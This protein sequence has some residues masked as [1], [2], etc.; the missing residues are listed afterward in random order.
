MNLVIF[1]CE[2]KGLSSLNSIMNEASERGINLFAMVCQETYLQ[3]PTQNRDKFQILTNCENTN[4]TYSKTLGVTLPFKPDWLLVSRERWD[5]ETSIILEFKQNFGCKVGLVEP[6]SWILGNAEVILEI[7]SRNRFKD[8]IDVFFTHSSYQ[9]T[10]QKKLGFVGNMVL[11]GNPKYDINLKPTDKDIQS[12]KSYYNVDPYRKKVLLFSLVNTNRK[13]LFKEF[14]KYVRDNPQY[15]FYFKPYPGEPFLP[16]FKNEYYPNFFIKGVTPILEESHIWAM[17]NICDIHI[18]C[19]SSIFH[20]SLLLNKKIIDLSKNLNIPSQY[21]K[22]DHILNS[23]NVGLE[24]SKSLW[25]RS[26][27]I[28]ENE[29]LELLCD[30]NFEII[31]N[32]NNSI[33]NSKENLLH[34]FDDFN[35]SKASKRILNYIENEK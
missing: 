18:G 25:M 27:N 31:K 32:N 3:H 24:D 23:N 29:L 6:N 19:L 5:P 1:A 13:K 7:Q 17:F 35:D 21:L 16:Q 22:K 14:E 9:K 26:L 8:V 12:V 33:W 2:A 10:T 28:N 11:V 15:Q 30:K 34:L 20:A 4:P